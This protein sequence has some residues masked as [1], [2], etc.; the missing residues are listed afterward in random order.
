MPLRT[1][2]RLI[3]YIGAAFILTGCLPTVREQA[4]YVSP[5]NGNSEDYHPLPMVRDSA[6]TAVYARVAYFSGL[7]NDHN[8]DEFAG[9]SA[10]AYATNRFGMVQCFYGVGLTLGGYSIGTWDTGYGLNY[11]RMLRYLPPMQSGQLQQYAGTQFFGSTA[12]SGGINLVAP[13][14]RGGEWRFF[15]LE[16]ALHRE[17]GDYHQF[18]E[19]LPDSVATLVI[20]S[21]FFGTVGL[22]SELIGGTKNGELGIRLAGGW[23]L[24][25]AYHNLNI[26]DSLGRRPLK[27]SYFDASFHFT[28]RRYTAY[29]Q[30]NGGT[31]ASSTRIG[32][33]YR[34]TRPR[35]SPRNPDLTP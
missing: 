29:F 20:R 9:G 34:L 32:L 28:F 14:G 11:Y 35:R 5:L 13:L 8:T 30:V 19:Q 24:G 23:I 6:R 3:P 2:S 27:Y 22:F 31:K 17:F 15:G 21:R 16:T 12:F 33:V 25:S 4:F 26:Y 10:A 7:S 18:R 1:F